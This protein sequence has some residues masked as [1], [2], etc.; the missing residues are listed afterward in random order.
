MLIEF[1]Y[2]RKEFSV[3]AEEKGYTENEIEEMLQYAESLN[4]QDLP[5]IFDQ[6]HFSRL[7][8]YDYAY[9]LGVVNSL[10]SFYKHYE[11]PKK[12]GGKRNIEEP[13]PSLKDIQ[14]WILK[15]ILESASEKNVSNVA[16]A[17]MPGVKLRDNARFHRGQKIVVALDL[18]DFF[19]SIKF[20]EVYGIFKKLGYNIS[21]SVLLTN[22]CLYNGSLPQGAPTSPMLSNLVFY[23]L[24]EKIYLYC[25]K[26]NIRYTRYADDLTFSGENVDVR[27]LIKYIRMLISTKKFI[28]NDTKTNVMTRGCAQR[29]TGIIVNDKLQAPKVY[30]DQVRQEIYYCI[31]YGFADHMKHIKLPEWCSTVSLYQHH[32]LGKINFILQINPKDKVFI[33]YAKWI[34][35]QMD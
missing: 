24:D 17:F 10:S 5:I 31:K 2:Y 30:R 16:K 22:L 3:I 26:R 34:K 7:V 6:Y 15:N 27:R 8:G 33:K 20:C 13:F 11:I 35:E 1:K 14:T 18:H 25:R 29:V 9:L 12:S 28:L 32:L 19:G 4:N 21:V 23:E